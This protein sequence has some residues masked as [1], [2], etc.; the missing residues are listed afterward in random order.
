MR[1]ITMIKDKY[2]GFSDKGM[3]MVEVLMGF[4]LLIIFL[5][6]LSGIISSSNK[7]YME[8]V[9]I[10]KLQEGLQAKLYSYSTVQGLTPEGTDLALVP[11]DAMPGAH[12]K[13][14]LAIDMYKISSSTVSPAD[15]EDVLN[16]DIYFFNNL[17]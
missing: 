17:P 8:A 14:D 3:T 11:S 5:G 2:K 16:V 12:D 9:D 10:R 13:I 4:V 15:Q 1:I 6:S 7:M